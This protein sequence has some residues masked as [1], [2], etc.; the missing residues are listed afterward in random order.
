MKYTE[1]NYNFALC[2]SQDGHVTH[3]WILNKQVKKTN[4]SASL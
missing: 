1:G 4:F 2:N 3:P